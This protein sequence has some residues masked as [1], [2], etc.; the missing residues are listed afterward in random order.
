MTSITSDEFTSSGYDDVTRHHIKR[1]TEI[2]QPFFFRFYIFI[3]MKLGDSPMKVHQ[4]LEYVYGTSSSSYDTV[5]RWIR[6][7]QSGE[8]DLRD[9][10]R[11]GAP[12]TAMNENAIELVGHAIGR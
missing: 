9:D 1:V 7:F 3:R 10:P 6:T 8:K 2:T 4:E 12:K 5:C 11:S